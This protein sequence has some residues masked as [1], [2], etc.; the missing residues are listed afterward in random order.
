MELS[1]LLI[2]LQG[3][4]KW[5]SHAAP[6]LYGRGYTGLVQLKSPFFSGGE[7]LSQSDLLAWSGPFSTL[8]ESLRKPV[9]ECLRIVSGV[10]KLMGNGRSKDLL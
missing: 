10:E 8:T 1:T 3:Q 2:H 6:A 5:H 4:S 7:L 9:E